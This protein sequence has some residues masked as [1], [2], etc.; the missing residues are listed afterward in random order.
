VQLRKKVEQ[1]TK[2]YTTLSNQV[3]DLISENR[4]LREMSGV[5]E[6]YGFNLEDIKLVEK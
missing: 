5:P 4:I 1:L 3:N 2:D 6:N